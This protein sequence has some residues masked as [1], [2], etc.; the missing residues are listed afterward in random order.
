MP[1]AGYKNL[2]Q[3]FYFLL[4]IVFNVFDSWTT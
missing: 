1:A 3:V 2:D 4:V